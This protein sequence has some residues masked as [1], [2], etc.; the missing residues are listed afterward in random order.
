[1]SSA[2]IS[3]SLPRSDALTRLSRNTLYFMLL[4]VATAA[5][6]FIISVIIGRGLGAAALGQ[7]SL[8]LAWSLTLAQFAD[9][10]MNTLLTR[11]LAQTPAATPRYLSASLVS[12]TVLGLG[13]ALWLLLFAP[14]LA[15]Q[16]ETT[17]A[18]QLS[19][20]LILLNAWFSSFLTVLRAFGRATPIL[21]INTAGLVAQTVLTY[22]LI[23][24]G[25]QVYAVILLV[26]LLQG[27]QCLAAALWYRLQFHFPAEPGR[28][29]IPFVLKLL[30]RALPFALAGMIGAVELRANV[31]LLG[32][33]EDERAVGYYSAASRITDGLRLAPNAFFG[34]LLPALALLGTREHAAAAR[35]LFRRAQLGLLA[36][37]VTAAIAITLL[38][39]PLMEWTYGA[40]F[41][42]SRSVLIVLGWGLVPALALGLLTL[43]LYAQHR[44]RTVN[45]VLTIGLVLHV[46]LAIPLILSYSAVGA[47]LAALISDCIV[48]ALLFWRAAPF[49]RN[50]GDAS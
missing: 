13:L 9:F 34:A 3:R 4:N 33:L 1:M 26:V 6:S 23:T 7:Y 44:E 41:E 36:F 40:Q 42:S 19:A 2:E 22:V 49:L 21:V 38:A 31:F 25:Y 39:Q 30:Q 20:L 14:V 29:D 46:G 12:K 8:A 15:P 43:L 11:E 17:I 24:A 32:W 16:P 18:L 5:F 37:G 48:W 28:T 45:I 35:R 10:G 27:I 47:A 50:T